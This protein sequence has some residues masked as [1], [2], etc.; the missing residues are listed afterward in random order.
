[1]EHAH[2]DL[3]R[4]NERLRR[5]LEQLQ[6]N[7]CCNGDACRSL[8]MAVEASRSGTWDWNVATGELRVDSR[9]AEMLGYTL[10]ELEPVTLDTFR[11][12]CHPDDLEHSDMLARE[13][14]EHNTP[15]Y[16]L[17]LRMRHK[18]GRWVWVVARGKVFERDASGNPVRMVGS[19]H[20]ISE[21][22]DAEATLTRSL[23]FER[24]I[25]SLSN[26]FISLG[27]EEIDGMVMNT[28]HL[29]GEFVGADRSYIFQFSDDLK[30][31]DNTHEWCAEGTDPQIDALKGLPTDIFPWWMERINRNES[32]LLPRIDELPPEASAERDILEEQDIKSLIVIPLA[33]GTIPFGYIGFD[34]VH[35]E[36]EWKAD[37]VSILKFAG[38]IIAN[39]LQRQR[40][41]QCIQA[42]LE[43]ALT[44]NASISFRETLAACLHA[45]MRVSGMDCGGIYLVD[46]DEERIRL[47]YHEGL[48]ET[49]VSEASSYPFDSENAR[50]IRAGRPIYDNFGRLLKSEN[51]AVETENLQAIA[52]IPILHKNEVIGNLNVASHTLGQ[53]PEFS[54]KA[55]ETVTAHIGAAIMQAR[56][57]EEIAAT[58]TNFELLFDTIE[59]FLFIVDM[60]GMVIHTNE[61]VR[62]RL[63]YSGPELEGRHVLFFHPEKQRATAEAN[64]KAMLEGTGDACLVPLEAKNG[65]LIPVETRVTPGTWNNRP[66]LFGTSRDVT[67]RMKAERILMESERRFRELTEFLPLP[68]FEVDAEGMVTYSNE[69]ATELFGYTKEEF[70]DNFPVARF[71]VP[72]ERPM[73][74]ENMRRMLGGTRPASSAEYTATRKDGSRIPMLLYSSPIIESGTIRGIRGTALDL[75]DLKKAEEALRNIAIQERL[76][77]EF[78]TLIDNI[79]GA[80]YRVNRE[81]TTTIL[82]MVEEF[83]RDFSK[84]QFERELFSEPSIIH[85]DDLEAVLRSNRTIGD[86]AV[87]ET[88]TYR[89][90]A[91]DGSARWIEDRRTP[92]Y[93][94][95]GEFQGIDGILF[96]ITERVRTQE[97]KL[98]LESR[99]RN[100]QR[101]ETI[102]TL[103]GGI[104]HDFNN[105]LTPVLGYAEMGA[106]DVPKE[107]RLHD[108]FTEIVRAAERAKTLVAQILTFSRAQES[109]PQAVNV[110]SIVTEALKLLRPSIPATIT[111]KRHLDE[112]CGNVLADPSQIHQV[113]VNLCTNAFQAMEESGG[114]LSLE[115]TRIEAGSGALKMFPHLE[116]SDCLH[117]S[118]ADTG[119]GMDKATMERIF[120]PFF[121][122]KS[123]NRGTGLG[124]SVVHGIITSYNGEISVESVPAKGST[125]HV[126]LPLI[127]EEIPEKPKEIML[128]K[129]VGH[130]LFVDDE[131][132]TNQ[133]MQELIPK[134][135]FSISCFRSPL[136]ALEAYRCGP[137]GFDIL[138]TDLTMP[139]M[140]GIEL[141]R[142]IHALTPAFPVI[143]MTG[144]GKDIELTTP[145]SHY[146]ITKFLKKPVPQSELAAAINEVISAT[147]PPPA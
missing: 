134:L 109:E 118:I 130:I 136:E 64:I 84:E 131:A 72:E 22:K 122:T 116:E 89:I 11:L 57:E 71:T 145:I 33:S 79:P 140:T 147:K 144:Y 32:I 85:P 73:A 15:F 17:E 129:G 7:A 105:I 112:A 78:R 23:A 42:E 47:A 119:P 98:E 100:S 113:I 40:A 66:V 94:G 103:A 45:A 38:G 62:R 143:L 86:S 96:D 63:G 50:I 111:I 59:D 93:A 76:V 51:R 117:L 52:I 106:L 135:G 25:T 95:E 80:V 26:R 1:M 21:R 24:L 114:V 8:E 97:D 29:I 10:E 87:S 56:H 123:V 88:I 107:D 77:S 60:E 81:G 35:K 61:T 31:M 74:L 14:F 124:L 108:Y 83:L 142:S 141:A 137:G 82:S 126:Y 46:K 68:L 125:F 49:F 43:L 20:D 44:L 138:I 27:Y 120:E 6:E 92:A 9:W 54:R 28:L 41:E 4:E 5:E 19:H 34:A 91:P 37:T 39:A 128:P 30:L 146:G 65:E 110:Q 121:T 104:A 70:A 53:V 55:L 36:M 101:L 69:K 3:R 139:E 132:A 133:L 75:T 127:N 58:K 16:E 18:E 90:V 102:G 99:L 13:H 48:P 115:L 2:E 12:R 67:E